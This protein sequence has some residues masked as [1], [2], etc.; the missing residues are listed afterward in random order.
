ML[1][2]S[3]IH[4]V[5][6]FRK[7]KCNVPGR[8]EQLLGAMQSPFKLQEFKEEQSAVKMNKHLCNSLRSLQLVPVHPSKQLQLLSPVHSP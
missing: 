5:V 1:H 6:G 2:E 3:P 4:P 7:L 8:Q